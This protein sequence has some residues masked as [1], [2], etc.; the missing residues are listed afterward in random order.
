MAV[1]EG[2]GIRIVLRKDIKGGEKATKGRGGGGGCGCG[3][4]VK[5]NRN[6]S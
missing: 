2:C 5:E 3:C 1:R 6:L 4:G